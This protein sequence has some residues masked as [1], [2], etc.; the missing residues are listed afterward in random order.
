MS[1]QWPNRSDRL[2]QLADRLGQAHTHRGLA[3]AHARLSQ[4][5]DAHAHFSQA[6]CLFTELGH[7]DA[8]RLH[9]MLTPTSASL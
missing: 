6:L 1:L 4:H 8:D 5:D 7:P 2:R 3:A 9:E